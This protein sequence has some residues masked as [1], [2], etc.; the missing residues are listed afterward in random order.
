MAV[1]FSVHHIE[2]FILDKTEQLPDTR[3]YVRHITFTTDEGSV[4]LSLFSE[5]EENLYIEM[6]AKNIFG[7][8]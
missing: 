3:D 4:I 6:I 1:Y 2:R 8:E 7:E 5:K